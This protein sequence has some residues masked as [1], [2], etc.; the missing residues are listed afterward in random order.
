VQDSSS[1]PSSKMPTSERDKAAG[2]ILPKRY[3]GGTFPPPFRAPLRSSASLIDNRSGRAFY[4]RLHMIILPLQS[5]NLNHPDGQ[6]GFSTLSGFSST[7]NNDLQTLHPPSN[8]GRG[9]RILLQTFSMVLTEDQVLHPLDPASSADSDSWPEFALRDVRVLTQDGR[10]LTSLFSAH[11]TQRVVVE[12]ALD[13]VD[14][15]LR[16]LGIS[17]RS[18][19][20]S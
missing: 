5:Y 4:S 10:R 20:I 11:P 7:I 3:L 17:S 18:V 2:N 14:R 8:P 1:N 6:P 15:D 9:G 16:H 13:K 19:P 12:A